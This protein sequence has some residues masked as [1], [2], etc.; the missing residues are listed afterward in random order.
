M[1]SRLFPAVL[2]LALTTGA[3]A[4]CTTEQDLLRG[5]REALVDRLDATDAGLFLAELAKLVGE[6]PQQIKPRSMLLFNSPVGL[7]IQWFDEEGCASF[8][9]Q[10]SG[11]LYQKIR[12][13]I[14]VRA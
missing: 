12:N 14:G 1:P 8:G 9:A 13:A 6:P 7:Q 10:M 3:Q 4:E 2:L 5:H 11:D